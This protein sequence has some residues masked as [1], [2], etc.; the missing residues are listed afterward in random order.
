MSKFAINLKNLLP[1]QYKWWKLPNFV[2]LLVGGYG[3]G[4]T[5]VGALR[6]LYLSNQ[7]PGMAG[8]YVSP[9]FSLAK[10]TIIPALKEILDR[11]GILYNY[12]ATDH[13]FSFTSFGGDIWIGS[14]DEP[15]TLIGQNL[16]WA[17]VDEPFIQS[18]IVLEK[19]IARVRIKNAVS[20]LFLTG[21]PE[22]LNWGYDMALNN[23]NRFD[24]G[25]VTAS[26]LDNHHT[27]ELYKQNLL[28]AYTEEQIKAYVEGQF[29][30]LTM[31]RVCKPF[32]RN[33]HV[34]RRNDMA[35][36][37][38]TFPI[39]FG[40]DFNVDYMSAE[41]FVDINGYM[42]FFDEIRLN[43][44]DTFE[45][46]E[47]IRDKYPNCS[48]SYPDATGKSRKSSSTTTDHQIL[49]DAGFTIKVKNSNPP[50]KNRVNTWNWLLKEKRV[51]IDPN[52]VNL[53]RDN[54]IMTWKNG[55]LNKTGDLS[56]THA[57]DAG[58][59]PAF[60]KYQLKKPNILRSAA[61]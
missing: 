30:N 32:N 42:H 45:I 58:S 3:S 16:A 27:S 40:I 36:L 61:W 59:Y 41:L 50:V 37:L 1:G 4:K 35:E 55:D 8:M 52:C 57:F 9:T 34:V 28:R 2:K 6:G 26:S 24:V 25:V 23:E 13:V 18:I 17:G 14:G 11:A 60:Y 22:E 20:E 51:T 5:Y 31:G 19:M 54:E 44:S 38:T 33:D 7:N 53:I 39:E 21:T 49:K 46:S 48:L 56:L 15:K 43:N 10:K 47:A 29:V 12:H